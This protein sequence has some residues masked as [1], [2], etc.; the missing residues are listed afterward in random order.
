MENN[1]IIAN[2]EGNKQKI[3]LI[4]EIKSTYDSIN[5]E[6]ISNLIE[7]FIS[8]LQQWIKNKEDKIPY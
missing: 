5:D 7:S 8:R 6:V 3:R 1:Q 2:E 4:L